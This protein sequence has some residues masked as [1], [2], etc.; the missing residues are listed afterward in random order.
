MPRGLWS[1]I[2]PTPFFLLFFT[3]LVT[4]HI[5]QKRSMAQNSN[6]VSDARS[7]PPEV[8]KLNERIAALEE[9]KY[10][11]S[12]DNYRLKT[13]HRRLK[14]SYNRLAG[15][16][17][18]LKEKYAAVK[19]ERDRL[20]EYEH[21]APGVVDFFFLWAMKPLL[22]YHIFS[23]QWKYE[24]PSLL[25]CLWYTVLFVLPITLRFVCFVLSFKL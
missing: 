22:L 15:R 10:T 3:T 16:F 21:W 11:L 7:S 20:T 24:F 18:R 23:F 6:T 8:V 4:W 17:L 2:K 5:L 12:V 9:S 14:K 25:L 13:K 1:S 19:D